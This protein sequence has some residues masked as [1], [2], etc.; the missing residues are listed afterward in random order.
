MPYDFLKPIL[1]DDLFAQ[2]SV[3]LDGATGL[4]L[5]NVADGSY[6][7]KA[8]FDDERNKA[9]NLTAQVTDLTAKYNEAN[10]K[11]G[12]VDALNA[13]ITQL[14]Q[15]VTDRD[16]KL[17]SLSTDYDIKD[18][19]RAAKAR[20]VD[21][22]FGLLDRAKIERKDGK[23]TGIDEQIKAI[24]D[25]KG[26]LFDSDDKGGQRG[27]FAGQQDIIGGNGGGGNAAI[28]DAIRQMAGRA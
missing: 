11:A 24:R 8:K 6:V 16:A 20:D 21:I 25:S 14:T 17:A 3:K 1:G 15:D 13:K 2:V 27:G 5:V 10:Q 26:F 18:A 4:N 7:P 23:L 12:S 28:N 19:L 9:K 22:V